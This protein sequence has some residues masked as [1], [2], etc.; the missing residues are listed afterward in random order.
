MRSGISVVI[1]TLNEEA[2]IERGVRQFEPYREETPIEVIVSDDGSV[3]STVTVAERWTDR[4][5]SNGKAPR[6]RSAA[7]NRGASAARYSTLLFLDADIRISPM[8]GFL[9]EVRGEFDANPKVVGA[10]MDYS[11]Y[12]ELETS[13]DWITHRAWNAVMRAVHATTGIG[14]CT[15]GFQ[16]AKRSSFDRIGGYDESMRLIQDVE[17]SF[18]LSRIGRIHYF[19]Q[20]R[21][22][23]S[24]RRYRDEGYVVYFWRSL[25][26]WIH[27]LLWRKSY[28]EYRCVR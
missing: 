19:K 6:G 3:D 14:L 10:M 25:L 28:G 26:R 24:P 15:P 9:R 11:V 4:V 12:P 20:A 5:V 16:M 13:G 21:I 22:L 2:V 23:E 7:L 18:R 17:F 1:P 8:E 27:L